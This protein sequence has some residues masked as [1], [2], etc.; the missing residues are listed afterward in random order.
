M[1]YHITT[2]G[3]PIRAT[4]ALAGI[5]FDDDKVPGEKWAELKLILPVGSQMPILHVVTDGDNLREP[6]VSSY[7]SSSS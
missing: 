3:E 5:P 1:N 2:L 4:F 6:S 7:S